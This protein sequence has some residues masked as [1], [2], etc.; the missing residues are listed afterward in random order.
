MTV[1]RHWLVQSQQR[2]H[3]NNVLLTSFWCLLLLTLNR[4][5]TFWCFHWW[6][7]TNKCQLGS[8]KEFIWWSNK[9]NSLNK[10]Y[11]L[12]PRT[13]FQMHVQIVGVLHIK[14]THLEDTGHTKNHLSISICWKC[15]LLCLPLWE[16]LYG[17]NLWDT[18]ADLMV[19]NTS[20]L[21]WINKKLFKQKPSLWQ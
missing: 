10:T 3:H 13:G 21:S 8:I 14:T 1:S 7:W 16:K 18:T 20:I 9:L 5:H 17:K 19:D 2:K 15:K 12:H 6:L 4:F 11:L